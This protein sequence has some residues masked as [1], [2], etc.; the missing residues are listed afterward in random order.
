MKIKFTNRRL[1]LNFVKVVSVFVTILLFILTIINF[2]QKTKV[3]IAVCYPL[4]AYFYY[5][6]DICQ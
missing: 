6:V 1:W 4:A 2:V 5:N 3:I